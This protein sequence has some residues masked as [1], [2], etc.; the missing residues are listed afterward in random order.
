M[1]DTDRKRVAWVS[2]ASGGIGRAIALALARKGCRVVVN[3]L[4]SETAA[5]QLAAEICRAGGEAR[6]LPADV[7]QPEAVAAGVREIE[8]AWGTID[9]LV[10]NAGINAAQPLTLTSFDQWRAVMAANLDAAFLLTKAVSRAMMRRRFGRIVYISSDAALLGDAMH[11]AYSA[12]K[13]GLLGLART[14]ARELAS[15]GVTVNVV[16]PGPI[17]TAMTADTPPAKRAKQLESIPM[18]RFGKPE[19]VAA[20]VSFLASDAAAYI[21]GQVLCV[22]GGL[23][24]RA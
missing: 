4:R 15:S 17:A 21:T 1:N 18:G 23:C 24:M 11:G 8:S 6:A 3:Y 5:T 20:V 14:A 13:A 19:E 2:G 7:S 16:A 9:I 12:S 22:D 10:S